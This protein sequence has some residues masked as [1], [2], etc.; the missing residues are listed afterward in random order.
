MDWSLWKLSKFVLW[1]HHKTLSM[2][3]QLRLF[4]QLSAPRQA[5]PDQVTHLPIIPHE[6]LQPTFSSNHCFA[7]A[8]AIITP[9]PKQLTWSAFTAPIIGQLLQPISEATHHPAELCGTCTKSTEPWKAP[10]WLMTH[11]LLASKGKKNDSC[12]PLVVSKI[13]EQYSDVTELV[14]SQHKPSLLDKLVNDSASEPYGKKNVNAVLTWEIQWF[15]LSE[16]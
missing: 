9:A 16:V 10:P 3:V 12:Q 14:L 7:S 15:G 11:C 1:S 13:T 2:A 5:S 8:A 6:Q 4:E